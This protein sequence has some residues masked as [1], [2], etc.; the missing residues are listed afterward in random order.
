M[1]VF[2][3]FAVVM[4][5]AVAFA[6]AMAAVML[7]RREE[8]PV[9]AFREFFFSGVAYGND[10]S[11][12]GEGLSG[13]RVV[14]IHGH[15]VVFHF[16]DGGV[17]HVAVPADH[18]QDAADLHQFLAD[19][20]LDGKGAL[21][22]VYPL[23]LVIGT[24]CVL[25]RDGKSERRILFQALKG[26]LEGGNEHVHALDVVHGLLRS[27]ALHDFAVRFQIVRNGHYFMIFDFHALQSI[28]TKAKVGIN[29][30]IH[31]RASSA[32]ATRWFHR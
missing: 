32:V 2:T 21:R 19:L 18:R 29:F 6:L 14:E 26:G 15:G 27:R 22:Q 17:N 1:F 23:F 11:P 25:G 24:V 28:F 5:M 16:R 8:F 10:L 4:V 9:K 12:E 31:K 20:A 30:D 7:L 13:H 3:A